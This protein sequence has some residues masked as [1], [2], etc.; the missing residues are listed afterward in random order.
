MTVE[1]LKKEVYD[2]NIALTEHQLV[3]LTWGNVSGIDRERGLVVIKPS[4]VSYK[5]LRPEDMVVLSLD[6]KAEQGSLRPSSDTPTHLELYRAY[7]E[8]G[9]V[10]HTH[11][12]NATAFAQAGREIPVYGTTHADTFH[13]A[14]RVSR[15][16]TREEVREGYEANTGKL[17]VETMGD[18]EIL[19]EPGVLI[20]G[21]G[22]FAWGKS[23]ADAVEHAVVM[24][25]VARLAI[26]T[27]QFSP[28]AAS[29]PDYISEK[30]YLRKHGAN[31]YYGQGK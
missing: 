26:L 15:F 4:G 30:H 14:V 9:G 5:S 2:A 29:L 31:A 12:A 11:S 3:I 20:R 7:P 24:E 22:P 25:E 8:L 17:I 27:E 23:P 16:L 28:E 19:S 10:V 18:A 6:G 13:G 1:T 21:H